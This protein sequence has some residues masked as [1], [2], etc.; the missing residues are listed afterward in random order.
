MISRSSDK[1]F[2]AAHWDW[3]VAGAGVLALAAAAVVAVMA[4]GVDPET[5]ADD[6]LA[7]LGGRSGGKSAEKSVHSDPSSW[8]FF[9]A[10]ILAPSPRARDF[11]GKTCRFAPAWYNKQRTSRMIP[12]KKSQCRRNVP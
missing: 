4:F 12:R 10:P 1:G 3:L 11:S 7:E 8:Q 2:L 9:C 5:A 6:A